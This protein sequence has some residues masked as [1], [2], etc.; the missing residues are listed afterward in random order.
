MV[1]AEKAAAAAG[2]SRQRLWYWETTGLVRPTIKRE[3]SAHS[4]VRLY[5]LDALTEL[6][7]AAELRRTPGITLQ[8]MRRVLGYLRTLGYASPLRELHFAVDRGEIYFQHPDGSWEGDRIPRQTVEPRVLNLDDVRAKA[9]ALAHA[10]R[11]HA[12]VG[13]VTRR[14]KVLGAKPVFK[15]TRVP[16]QAVLAYVDAGRS[17]ADILASYPSLTKEDLS[18][19]LLLSSVAERILTGDSAESLRERYPQLTPA[20]IESA[21]LLAAG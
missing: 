7:T 10:G 3:I 16:V 12:D 2:I 5:G 9:R 4:V 15:G 6:L 18:K 17:I 11:S 14:R 20:E 13:H 21:R 1:T 19:A 8:H